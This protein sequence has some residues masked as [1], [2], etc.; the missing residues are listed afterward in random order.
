[1]KLGFLTVPFGDWTLEQ[2]ADFAAANGFEV[3]EVAC[4]PREPGATRRYAGVTHI[5]AATLDR[6]GP[7]GPGRCSTRRESASRRSATTRTRCIP[8]PSV[9]ARSPSIFSR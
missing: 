2:V 6:P 3:L 8:T 1:M 5:D 4:W 9:A 7:S